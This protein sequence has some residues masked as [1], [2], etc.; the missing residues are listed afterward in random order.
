MAGDIASETLG[1]S[2]IPS[3]VIEAIPNAL[4]SIKNQI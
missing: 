3:D 2:L 4:K 1:T